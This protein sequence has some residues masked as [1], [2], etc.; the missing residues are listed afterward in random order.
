LQETKTG[1]G[2]QDFYAG[3]QEYQK[4]AQETFYGF[5]DFLSDLEKELSANAGARRGGDG[6]PK[7]LWEELE[8]IGEEFVDFLEKELG[9]SELAETSQEDGADAQRQRESRESAM[10]TAAEA[11]ASAAKA[12]EEAARKAE[13]EVDQM[14]SELKKKLGL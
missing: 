2:W 8:A 6:E 9:I 14:L 12:G 4:Q 10:R 5:A 7:S 13:V 3:P 11:A 1:G